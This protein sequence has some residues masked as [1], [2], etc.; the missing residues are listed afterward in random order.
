MSSVELGEFQFMRSKFASAVFDACKAMSDI[1]PNELKKYLRCGYRYLA[2]QLESMCT[3]DDM[4]EL[5]CDQCSLVDLRLLESVA[6][7]FKN[8]KAMTCIE[9]Y[10]KYVQ[11]FKSLRSF[12]DKDLSSDSALESERIIIIVDR[13]VDDCT[14]DDV[15]LLLTHAFKD[16]APHVKIFVIKEHHSFIVT[17]SFPL[18]LSEQLI[19][20]AEENIELLKE[21][22]VTKLTIG[23]YTMHNSGEV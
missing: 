4:L 5:V 18:A 13:N 17:C 6:N 22:G 2:L 23:Y 8:E 21:K 10:M 15:K 14:I 19:A 7:H 3:T 11:D 20:T 9:E 16:L 12:I 1:P